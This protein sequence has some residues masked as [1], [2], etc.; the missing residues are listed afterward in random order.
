MTS[1]VAL[2]RGINVGGRNKVDMRALRT[3][4][5]AAGCTAVRTYI[6]SG[7][8][9]FAHR[10]KSATLAPLLEKAIATDVGFPVE[11]L[12]RDHASLAATAKAIPRTWKDDATMR[13]YVLFLFDD[14]DTPEVVDE[15]TVKRG[16]DH[17]RYVPGALIWRVARAD[18]TRSGMM[19]LPGT[20]LYRSTTIRNCN[21]VRKLEQLSR[22]TLAT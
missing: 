12:L 5:E 10:R 8:V 14:V 2:L 21:T 13:C 1:Y 22:Q 6:N 7:N 18:L 16:I 19:K 3:T 11:V 9:L 20:D 4:F 15:V 17:V